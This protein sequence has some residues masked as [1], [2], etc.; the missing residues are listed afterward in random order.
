MQPTLATPP[1]GGS[2]NPTFGAPM[3]KVEKPIPPADENGDAGDNTS[4]SAKASGTGTTLSPRLFQPNDRTTS[5]PIL[6]AGTR[7]VVYREPA[8]APTQKPT[9]DDGGWRPSTR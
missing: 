4:D 7:P 2:R 5:Y 8:P 1:A 3:Q 9:I 6:R